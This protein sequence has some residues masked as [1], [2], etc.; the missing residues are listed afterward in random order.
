MRAAA[1]AATATATAV[2][3]TTASTTTARALK[4]S[5]AGASATTIAASA[6]ASTAGLSVAAGTNAAGAAGAA[7]CVAFP[8][9]SGIHHRGIFF[10]GLDIRGDDPI[11]G[12]MTAKYDNGARVDLFEVTLRVPDGDHFNAESPGQSIDVRVPF[13]EPV[14]AV[15]GHDV[16]S[17]HA[18][19]NRGCNAAAV[20]P[21][22]WHRIPSF[23]EGHSILIFIDTELGFVFA[24]FA[25]V[26]DFTEWLEATV[27]DEHFIPTGIESFRAR[28]DDG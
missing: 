7:D 1:T 11:D 15:V 6:A 9:S 19:G 24:A 4:A 16:E 27:E 12:N 8:F 21:V 28:H 25:V 17:D 2:D 14:L 13:I 20:R 18:F 23:P 22:V 3:A 5:T 26:I 10:F